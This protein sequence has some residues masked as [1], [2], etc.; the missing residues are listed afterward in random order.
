MQVYIEYAFLDNFIIDFI[1]LKISLKCAKI[2]TSTLRL[3]IA[4]I[5]GTILTII[6]SLFSFKSGFLLPIKVLLGLFI[7]FLGGSYVKVKDYFLGSLYFFLFTFLSGGTIIALFNLAGISYEN[8]FLVNYDSIIPIGVTFLII[9]L[10][11][12]GFALLIENIIKSK[13]NEN[14]FRKCEIVIKGKKLKVMGYIDTGNKLYDSLTGLPVIIASKN[15]IKRLADI[16]ALPN[17]Y[18]NLKVET[19][20]G[21]SIIK[22][23]YIDKLLIYKGINM[24]IYNNVLLGEGVSNFFIGESCELLLHST[25]Y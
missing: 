16:S 24:N 11:T 19:V 20:N 2:K 15:L 7:A 25:L 21:S 14:F 17:T 8:Y 4:S 13:E 6:L 1:L 23:F 12:K 10:F 22:I 9:Y 3:I 18:K 5:I